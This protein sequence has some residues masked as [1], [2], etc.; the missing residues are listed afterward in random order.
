MPGT[1]RLAAGGLAGGIE[2][3]AVEGVLANIGH[4]LAVDDRVV[5]VHHEDGARQQLQFIDENAVVAAEGVLLVV[6]EELDA[7]DAFGGAT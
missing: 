6:G 1:R 4:D 2:R 7:V 3:L 5:G